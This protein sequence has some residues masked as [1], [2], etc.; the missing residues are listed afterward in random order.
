[1]LRSNIDNT[2]VK[3]LKSQGFSAWSLDSS[4]G[5]VVRVS[6]SDKDKFLK[7]IGPC[8]VG[9]Y[10]YKWDWNDVTPEQQ[11]DRNERSKSMSIAA[12][13]RRSRLFSVFKHGKFIG[14]F[15]N[16]SIC[17]SMIN[18]DHRRI[19]ECLNNKRKSY[20]YFIFEYVK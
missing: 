15:K 13:K 20:N 17:A 14:N 16:H 1:M 18:I 3:Y 19:S 8:P 12:R 4:R 7:F 9:C 10:R 2:I 5:P 11:I 6:A